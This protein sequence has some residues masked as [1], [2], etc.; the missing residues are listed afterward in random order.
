MIKKRIG[1]HHAGLE[2]SDRASVVELFLAG[3]L[4]VLCCTSTLAVGVISFQIAC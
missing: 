4:L 3:K 1:Y 2:M